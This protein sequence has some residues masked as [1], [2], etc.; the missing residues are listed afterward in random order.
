MSS[1]SKRILISICLLLSLAFFLPGCSPLAFQNVNDLLRAPELG[2]GQGEIQK[3]LAT[4]LGEQPEYKYPKEGDWRSP[5]ILED[6]NGDG[7]KEGV[8]L[9]SLSGSATAGRGNNVYVAVLE[10]QQGA[11]VVTQ[12]IE[13]PGTE[14]A[15]FETTKLLNNGKSQLLVGFSTS[16]SLG[17]KTLSIYEYAGGQL[18]E[19]AYPAPYSRYELADF[20]GQGGIELVIVSPDDQKESM[21]LQYIPTAGGTLDM[22]PAPVML[23]ANFAS[24]SGIYPT[25][26]ETGERM[27]ILDGKTDK[28]VLYSD[29]LRFSGEHFYKVEDGGVLTGETAR[30]NALLTSRD[31]DGDGIVEIPQRLGLTEI[32]TLAGDKKLEY[33]QWID[34][35]GPEAVSKQFGLVDT[36]KGVYIRLP[37]SW[38]DTVRV[39]DGQNDGEWY[40]RREDTR[41]KLLSL[42]IFEAGQSP[43][44]DAL[45]VS[46]V[47]GAYLVPSISLM[48]A[49]RNLISV[50]SLF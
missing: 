15:S 18:A 4:Y 27:L 3:A 8:L 24:C 19:L 50:T 43:P 9:Y 26:S 16:S 30:A 33:V 47:S 36:G 35:T 46:R 1:L 22:S 25:S 28:G 23:D 12:D 7:S 6:L 44:P 48:A 2:R 5:L 38:Q 13:G 20:S 10:Y 14:V 40:I 11:W 49:E 39:E 42:L 37:E 41:E 29:I 31:I 17:N 34:F 21:K 45:L 32:V